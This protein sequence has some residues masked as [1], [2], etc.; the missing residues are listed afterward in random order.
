MNLNNSKALRFDQISAEMIKYG[1][2]ELHSIIT[3][4]LNECIQNNVDI[5]TG[6]GLLSSI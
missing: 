3:I 4:R 5:E 2:T 1:H 6:F